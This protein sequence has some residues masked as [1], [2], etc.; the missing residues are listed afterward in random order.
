M[1]E[2][3]ITPWLILITTPRL[4]GVR[5]QKILEFMSPQDLIE[6]P[7][8]E[9]LSLKFS[10]LQVKHLTATTNPNVDKCLEWGSKQGNHLLTS[11]AKHYPARLKEIPCYPPLLFVQGNPSV[12]S[13]RQIGIVGSRN[14]TQ[15]GLHITRQFSTELTGMGMTIT[16]GLALGI[17]GHAHQ[18]CLESKG[19]TVAV[20]GSG[21]DYLYPKQH[22]PLAQRIKKQGALVSEFPPFYP[23]KAYNFPRR[24][25]IISGLS[26]AV[27][28][29]EAAERSGSLITARFALEQGRDVYVVPGSILNPNAAGC[30]GLIR[31][32]AVLVRN[33]Q[34]IMQEINGLINWS[35][36]M[37]QEIPTGHLQ[38]AKDAQE[39][40]EEV[41]ENLQLIDLLGERPLAVDFLS[42]R[43]HLPVNQVM[44]Q[45]LEL[46]LKGLAASVV[47]GYI[48]LRG[49]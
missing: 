10:D 32:G 1:K 26:V 30:N 8:K 39:V 11:D 45:L 38:V 17:D 47:G 7:R 25:R 4:S 34:D 3:H 15:D 31:D 16:S 24:N 14:S 35:S 19:Q 49:S 42:E 36:T 43:T 13:S 23:P 20:L 9:L 37:Q 22:Q 5:L 6:L 2:Q 27:L 40:D 46:E 33:G 44:M 28:V 29:I 18:A 21:F 48:R 12:L 41:S